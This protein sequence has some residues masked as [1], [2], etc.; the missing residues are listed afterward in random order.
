MLPTADLRPSF[1]TAMAEYVAE[2][3]GAA[4]DQSNVGR[5]IR[6][7][8]DRWSA[9][10]VFA[11]FVESVRAQ[12]LAETPRPEAFVPTTTLW[13]VAGEEY[14]GR[15]AIRHRLAPGR[16]GERNGHIGYDV[17]PSAR[18]R[19][20]A[21][22]MLAAARPWAARRGLTEALITCDA[23]NV[24]S[25]RVIEANGGIFLDRLDEKLRYRLSTTA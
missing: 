15:L 3:R 1:L 4:D 11:R 2:G 7:F 5:D 20:H 10:A 12:E 19:G 23:G 24:A 9:P 22:A 18:R 21:T 14:L 16:I 25:R 17:R 13:W 8:G 6:M